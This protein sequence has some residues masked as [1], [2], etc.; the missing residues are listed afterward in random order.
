[1]VVPATTGP[2]EALADAR[3]RCRALA[4]RHGENFTVVSLLAPRALR[5]HLA[6]VYAYCRAVDDLGDEGRLPCELAVG[7]TAAVPPGAGRLVLLDSFER[8]LDLACKGHPASP[9]FV[10]LAATMREFDLPREPF[11][12]LIEANRID[13][14]R[15]RYATY[16]E[17]LDY[18]E[19]SA[20]SVG[21][22][23]L[24]LY[25]VHG[26]EA[27]RLSDATCTALQLANFWQDVKRDFAMGRIY[28]PQEDLARFGVPESDLAADRG[29]E[30]F[31]RLLEFEV[32]R[33]RSLFA[34]GLPL[35]DR[36][37]GHLRVDLALF[38]RGGL[39]ILDKIERQSY[40]TLVRRPRLSRAEKGSIFLKALFRR[41]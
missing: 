20:T 33:A 10:A 5:A 41:R 32:E 40:D 36:V 9:L 13:Q 30:A 1:M 38:L 17:L 22:I 6:V 27:E 39:A 25:R 21:R 2:E 35:A 18:C 8:D 11:R 15:T 7:D 29:S 26:A 34:E 3:A 28:L 19:H 4:R 31:R 16:A 12:R 24:G 37:S 14:T 23:V